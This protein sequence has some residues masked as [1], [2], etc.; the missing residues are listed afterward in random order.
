MAQKPGEHVTW[1]GLRAWLPLLLS[2]LA[3]AVSIGVTMQT[4]TNMDS[5]LVKA[6]ARLE[7]HDETF[8]TVQVQLAE[9]QRDVSYI[10]A[11]LEKREP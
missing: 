9:I 6:E 1:S 8:L 3:I 5:R 7:R 10:R 2:I 4:I 11:E